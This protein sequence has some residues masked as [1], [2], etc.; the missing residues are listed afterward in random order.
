MDK[1]LKLGFHRMGRALEDPVNLGLAVVVAWAIIALPVTIA[2]T[3]S[4]GQG[5]LLIFAGVAFALLLKSPIEH[6]ARRWR[7][8]R[9]A[10]EERHPRFPSH[11]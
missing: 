3:L 4:P 9:I 6:G 10:L 8:G 2:F 11:A 7:E 5:L 1:E